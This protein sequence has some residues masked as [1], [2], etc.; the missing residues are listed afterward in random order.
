MFT[1]YRKIIV[2]LSVAFMSMLV[3]PHAEAQLLKKLSK[4]LEKVNKTI[5]KVDKAKKNAKAQKEESGMTTP[6]SNMDGVAS[7]DDEGNIV[8]GE[9]DNNSST[10]F[11]TSE[12][13]FLEA[14][15]WSVSNVYDGVFS[16]KRGDKYEFWK[17]DG[18]KLFDANWESCTA[19]MSQ[20]EFHCGVVAMRRA[21]ENTYKRGNVCLLYTDGRVKEMDSSWDR[22]TNFVD[23]VA[24][25]ITNASN[26]NKSFY[27]DTTG[28]NIYPGVSIDGTSQNSIRP[29]RDGLRAFVKSYQEWGYIDGNGVVKLAPK[30]KSAT[31]FSEG[32][33]WVVMTDDTKHLI[34][35]T[36]KSVFQA[37]NSNSA[38]SDV[39][40]GRFYVEKGNDVC[41]YDL[42]GNLLKCFEEGNCFY[43]GYA[44]VTEP[45]S[46][47]DINS[48]VIDKDMN[49]VR[50]MSWEVVPSE[51]VTQHGPVFT[52]SGLASVNCMNGSYLIKPNGEVV[53]SDFYNNGMMVKSFSPVSDSDYLLASNVNINDISAAAILKPTGEI[54]WLITESPRLCGPYRMG[55][56]LFKSETLNGNNEVTLK[57][58][59][60]HQKPIGGSK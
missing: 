1:N 40:D 45:K 32:H 2:M 16:V 26:R 44:Y 5:E 47:G 8:S 4:G 19:G 31:D 51:I 28:K 46:F 58:V 18:Q 17:A 35:K 12:T 25:V 53:L 52:A 38:T 22:V 9:I 15:P 30:Y 36:G 33:A 11:L 7:T 37:P 24:I 50:E 34:D 14:E 43:G 59:D 56:P 27:I 39:V 48:L 21:S 23:G 6:N 10:P 49:V 13:L 29:L 42:Q 3:L 55:F 41:Y 20:P 60:I 57:A 54:V